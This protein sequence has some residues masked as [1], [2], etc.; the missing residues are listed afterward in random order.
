M[1]YL[2]FFINDLGVFRFSF[3]LWSIFLFLIVH[4][5]AMPAQPYN[6]TIAVP[7]APTR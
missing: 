1:F 2:V 6:L 5:N 4:F 3:I 7:Q